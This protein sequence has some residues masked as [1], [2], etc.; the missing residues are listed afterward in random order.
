MMSLFEDISDFPLNILPNDGT[1]H[2]YGKVFSKEKS[3]F[4][5]DYLFN[6]IPWEN[7]EAVIFGKLILTKR[8]VAW[9]GEKVFEYTYSK[10][11]KYAQFWTPELLELKQKCEE[12][13]GEIYNSC[14]LN[15]YHD[16]SEGMAYHSDGEKDLKKHGAIASLTF[17]AER[18]F[19]FKHKTTKE[20]VEIFLENGSLLVMKGTT[21]DNWMHRLPPTTKVKT[22]RVNLTFRTI[23]E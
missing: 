1:V 7:D 4:Y 16:G 3:D 21:Q 9:F 5:Y 13:S 18:K 10:R 6:Q 11:T 12:V 19:L 17:G 15:L 14:L 20:K 2:Y 23:E 8:K 22:P